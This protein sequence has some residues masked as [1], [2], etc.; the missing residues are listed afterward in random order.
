[1]LELRAEPADGPA[2]RALFAEYMAL[3]AQ[4]LGPGF[5]PTEAIFASEEAFGVPD[6]AWLVGYE[7]GRPVCCGGL[8]PL[9]GGACE[10]K[11]MFV[12]ASSR[13][14]G[15]GRRLLA[16]LEALAE[17]TGCARVRVLTTEALV[18][19][20][21]LY[22]A[23][24]YRVVERIE[25]GGH[26]DLWLEKTLPPSGTGESPKLY[27]VPQRSDMDAERRNPADDITPDDA[28]PGGAD[29]G[30]EHAAP[31]PFDTADEDP[32]PTEDRA[33][34]GERDSAA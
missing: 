29:S 27:P 34:D 14:R 12:A 28:T 1:M 17:A 5:E 10:I 15:H 22:A 18:E 4:R 3:V 25:A 11:R 9:A 32:T 31:A 30:E 6:A 21:A 23:T 19:A 8:R 2:A 33:K 16:E 7:D 20:R 13:G 24:G 26:T